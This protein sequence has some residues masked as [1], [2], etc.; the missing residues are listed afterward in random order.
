[1]RKQQ[2]GPTDP[3]SP[4]LGRTP[5]CNTQRPSELRPNVRCSAELG[6]VAGLARQT[7]LQ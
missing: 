7:L 1:M 5:Y 2:V 3:S 4:A 6:G